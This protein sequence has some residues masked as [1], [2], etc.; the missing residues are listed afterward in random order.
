MES[1]TLGSGQKGL[2]LSQIHFIECS[3]MRQCY[4]AISSRVGRRVDEGSLGIH[5]DHGCGGR[6]G[7]HDG[8]LRYGEGVARELHLAEVVPHGDSTIFSLSYN[9]AIIGVS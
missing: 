8:D 6:V 2:V 5:H 1:F 3:N 9:K 4:L 7:R